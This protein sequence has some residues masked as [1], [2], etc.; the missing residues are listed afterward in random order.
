[1]ARPSDLKCLPYARR[2]PMDISR[3]K[4]LKMASAVGIPLSSKDA[5]ASGSEPLSRALAVTFELYVGKNCKVNLYNPGKHNVTGDA[6][7]VKVKV[8]AGFKFALMVGY[9]VEVD[10]PMTHDGKNLTHVEIHV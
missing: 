3:R 2:R 6:M 7:V 4:V 9:M 5:W 1:M 8:P 10:F